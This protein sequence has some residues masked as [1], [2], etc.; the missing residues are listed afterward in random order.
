MGA[1]NLNNSNI[2]KMKKYYRIGKDGVGLWYNKQGQFTGNIHKD[3]FKWLGASS[4]PM[5]FEEEL[6]GYISVADS[7][8]HLYKWFSLQEILKL[9][10]DGFFVEV[11]ESD[12]V[13]FHE[14]YNHNVIKESESKL[15]E[16]ITLKNTTVVSA[17]PGTGK[18]YTSEVLW[19]GGLKVLDSDSSSF[20]W[21]PE[22][23]RNPYFPHNYIR[24]IKEN[25]GLVDYIFV[26][27][28]EEVRH[29]LVDEG[30][31]FYLIYPKVGVKDE[32][33]ERYKRRGS[34]E[35]FIEL[36]SYQW[37]YWI[38]DLRNQQGCTHI[39]LDTGQYISTLLT[40][41]VI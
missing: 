11:W 3:E 1:L 19:K 23:V 16:R 26:S 22:G 35:A 10:Q 27:S 37:E 24:H 21:L 4:L 36:I 12:S 14:M 7:L 34:P 29:A 2:F 30:I 6:V 41:K 9:Q 31:Q 33:I 20:S 28:H 39:E 32:Y 25:I 38:W 13:K 5:P 40:S 17:F 8:P 15:V 18:T